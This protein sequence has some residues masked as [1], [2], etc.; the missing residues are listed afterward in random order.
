MSTPDSGF[1][2][3]L[4]VFYMHIV[5][6]HFQRHPAPASLAADANTLIDEWGAKDLPLRHYS[7]SQLFSR[8][9]RAR[10]TPPDLLPLPT[11]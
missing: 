9:A 5:G 11:A 6:L 2:E 8:Q 3:T 10:W 4:T 7:A 1:H